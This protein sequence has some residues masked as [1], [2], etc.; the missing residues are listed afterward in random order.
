MWARALVA[1]A[2][3]GLLHG[4]ELVFEDALGVVEQATDQGALA[5]VDAAR[6]GEPE[7]AVVVGGGCCCH[8]FVP[9][10]VQRD[11]LEI[12]F[13]FA[14]LHG[15]FAALVVHASSALRDSG[16]GHLI[17]DLFKGVGVAFKSAGDGQV[18]EGPE[19]DMHHFG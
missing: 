19:A 1:A 7:E 2:L 17:D 18:T 15:A 10:R 9:S 12:P 4:G 13:F 16:G 6:G 5:V 11:G 8:C 14:V 3:A